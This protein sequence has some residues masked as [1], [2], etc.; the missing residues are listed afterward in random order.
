M[1]LS[2]KMVNDVTIIGFVDETNLDS[3]NSNEFLGKVAQ[4]IENNNKVVIDLSGVAFLDSSGIG[5]LVTIWR[6]ATRNDGDLRLTGIKPAVRTIFEITRLH[7]VFEIYD[8]EDVAV[9]S[10]HGI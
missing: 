2:I 6:N 10:F 7:R 3:N 9:A 1:N 4:H 5:C 8:D